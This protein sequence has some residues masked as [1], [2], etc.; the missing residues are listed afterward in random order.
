MLTLPQQAMSSGQD[1]GLV[2]RCFA[3]LL[4]LR[5]DLR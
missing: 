4:R 3:V 1:T 2:E 5:L